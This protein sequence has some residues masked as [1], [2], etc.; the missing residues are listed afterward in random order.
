MSLRAEYSGSIA[1]LLVL[2]MLSIRWNLDK[3]IPLVKILVDKKEVINRIQDG[4]PGLSIKRHL[5][6]E[7]DL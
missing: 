2:H 7:Y 3:T 6:P 4:L 1:V 5:V